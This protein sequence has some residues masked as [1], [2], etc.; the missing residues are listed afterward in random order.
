MSTP[1]SLRPRA[2]RWRVPLASLSLLALA[3]GALGVP[4]ASAATSFTAG[5]VVDVTGT[6]FLWVADEQGV[7]HLVGDT[8][9]LASHP[10]NWSVQTNLTL[11][12]LQ[13]ASRGDPWLSAALVKI[14]DA[15]YLPKWE[16]NAS[17]PTLYHVQSP[18]DLALMG[19]T[20][21]NYG[22]LVLSQADW[23]RQY[24]FSVD[25]LQ[26][27]ELSPI[28]AATSTT[29]ATT[30][31]STA[32]S[33]S[34]A[35]LGHLPVLGPTGDVSL[36]PP[37]NRGWEE[38]MNVPGLADLMPMGTL[39]GEATIG[40]WRVLPFPDGAFVYL[41]VDAID[42]SYHPDVKT[43]ADLA[44][45]K[46]GVLSRDAN[47]FQSSGAQDATYGGVAAKV[48]DSYAVREFPDGAVITDIAGE[49]SPDSLFTELDWT[50]RDVYLIRGNWGYDIRLASIDPTLF[51]SRVQ[52]F[53]QALSSLLFH[54]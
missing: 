5:E 52:D 25:S 24:G 53:S 42:L 19:I 28:T 9:A 15:I 47:S 54:Y 50:M 13:Q 14:G 37:D 49:A 48:V 26:R 1:Q 36:S 6:P 29:G 35:T 4:A 21:Q 40:S 7:V 16:T 3:T 20:A 32:A 10:V 39:P 2:N 34:T 23:E 8:R 22:S 30:S 41:R 46:T 27:A 43:V 31:A 18:N 33:M 44:T 51:Q 12:Q 17:A 11:D 38:A 45:L